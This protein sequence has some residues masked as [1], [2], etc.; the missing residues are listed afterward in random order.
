MRV[1]AGC[2]RSSKGSNARGRR[3]E[4]VDD[5]DLRT[6]GAALGAGDR[7]MRLGAERCVDEIAGHGPACAAGER[8]IAETRSEEQ[9][10]EFQSLK[11]TSYAVF[12]LKNKTTTI[13]RQIH[14]CT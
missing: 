4:A 5:Q 14:R 7:P 12:C 11:R 9:T 3:R 8:C 2:G 6:T 13:C 10:S 1:A